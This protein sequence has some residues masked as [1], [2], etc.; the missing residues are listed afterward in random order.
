[1]NEDEGGEGRG[2]QW[3]GPQ[4]GAVAVA[5]VGVA[6]VVGGVFLVMEARRAERFSERLK[7]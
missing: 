3:E 7:M 5:V 4:T 6:V 2:G 1:M